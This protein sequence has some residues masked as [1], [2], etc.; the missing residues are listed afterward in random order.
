VLTDGA[1]QGSKFMWSQWEAQ[2]EW[3]SSDSLS[4]R[5][6]CFKISR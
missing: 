4:S 5:L 1:E 6:G 2:S 3:R